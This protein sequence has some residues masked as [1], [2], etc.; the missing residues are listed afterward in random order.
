[1]SPVRTMLRTHSV[2]LRAMLVFTAILGIAYPGAILLAGLAVPA[3]ANGSLV[4][5]AGGA[6]VGSSLLAQS[7][8]DADGKPLPGWFQPR[9]SAGGWDA[10]ASGGTNL[11]PENPDLISAITQRRDAGATTPDALTASGSGLDPDIS[12]ENALSQVPAVAAARG[13]D[14]GTVRNLVTSMIRPRDLGFL[15]DERV[16][17]LELNL[18]LQAL[19]H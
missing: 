17:V 10:M 18:A 8:S 9:P 19:A 13:L 1:M 6:V 7:F 2:A 11:G 5:D 3:A 12:P 16:N 4:K 14:E 15:G